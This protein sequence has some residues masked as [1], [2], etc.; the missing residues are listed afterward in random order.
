MVGFEPSTVSVETGESSRILL[1]MI[2]CPLKGLNV[3]VKPGAEVWGSV[4]KEFGRL[5][6]EIG[7][8]GESEEINSD[9][10]FQEHLKKHSA[11]FGR[12]RLRSPGD[13]ESVLRGSLGIF[14]G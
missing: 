5:L 14:L 9:R 11:L 4:G 2:W 1:E 7:Q 12:E 13:L 6:K 8:F 3:G 10:S